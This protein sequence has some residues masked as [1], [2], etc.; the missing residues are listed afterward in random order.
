MKNILFG[1]LLLISCSFVYGQVLFNT[2]KVNLGDLDAY[3]DRFVDIK[4]TNKG[5][6]QEY[7]LTV[8][9]PYE[10][11]YL[12]QGKFMEPDSSIILRFQVNPKVKGKFSY[13]IDVFISDRQEAQ[14]I[15]IS[16][17]LMELPVDNTTAFT[18]CPD[19]N[20]RPGGE[21][22]DEFRL[23]V[24]TIDKETKQELD[25][26][27]VTLIQNGAPL[28]S[29]LTDK[30]GKIQEKAVLGFSY[31]YAFHEGYKKTE[32]GAYINF[33]RNYIVLELEK[34]PLYCPPPP[35]NVVVDV[36]P[37]E[38]IPLEIELASEETTPFI[39]EKPF[40]F[41]CLPKD[42]FSDEY[43]KPVNVIFVLDISASMKQGDKIELMKYSLYQLTEMLRPQDR[44]GIV[45]Y[46]SDARVLLSPT[47]GSNK[48]DI[49]AEVSKL[50][51]SGMT[52]GGA[53]IKLGYKQALKT[54]SKDGS[55]QIIVITD[56]AFNRSSDDY[57]KYIKKY[58]KKGVNM[59]VVGI[60]IKDVDKEKMKEDAELGGGR[61]VPIMKLAD[62]QI[63]LKQEIRFSC[64]K[65]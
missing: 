54:Y 18:A 11:T 37:E 63:N 56:G 12:I 39:E 55:N 7:L 13:T 35:Q 20:S 46:A 2:T 10:V 23:T 34:D 24:V 43:F 4:L 32:M 3:D 6:K 36:K 38:E 21:R 59:S 8:K 22:R 28:W 14:Q 25:R 30:E 47:S 27:K 45:T 48:E 65:F 17:N 61:L 16:G 62:A 57:K 52:A 64:F 53:G 19:F 58:K 51:A 15:K 50:K 26:S 49:K 5:K 29:K 60:M 40:S 9:K 1:F 44:M 31:F 42:N 33:Q 41:D